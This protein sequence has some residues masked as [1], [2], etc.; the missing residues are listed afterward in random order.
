MLL[1]KRG[2]AT[3]VIMRIMRFY[4]IKSRRLDF[5]LKLCCILVYYFSSLFQVSFMFSTNGKQRAIQPFLFFHVG[6]FMT[7]LL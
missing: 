2:G 6:L 5:S 3:S 7:M 4:P 1:R